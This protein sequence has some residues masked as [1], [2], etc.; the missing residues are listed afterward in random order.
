MQ[1]QRSSGGVTFL[2]LCTAAVAGP[3]DRAVGVGPRDR[4]QLAKLVV[5]I[6][7]GE[8]EEREAPHKDPAT[9]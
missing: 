1:T 9:R 2:R 7:T 6:A 5:D 8:A 4:N 3:I